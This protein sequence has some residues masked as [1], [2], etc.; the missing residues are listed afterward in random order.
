M[1]PAELAADVAAADR[2]LAS[3]RRVADLDLDPRADR[4]AVRSR[5]VSWS[6]SQLPI[7]AGA[8]AS[9]E[10]TFRQS[11]TGAP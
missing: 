8:A 4:V 1:D 6:A 9:P 5:L 2:Q 3:H 10:P 11:L 7:G